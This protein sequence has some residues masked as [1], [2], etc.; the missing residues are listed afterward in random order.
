MVGRL[1]EKPYGAADLSSAN[2]S[3]IG[4]FTKSVKRDVKQ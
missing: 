1:V 3:D 4:A 2:T